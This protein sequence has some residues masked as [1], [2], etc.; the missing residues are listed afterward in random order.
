MTP[1]ALLVLAAALAAESAAAVPQYL[2][3]QG[4]LADSAGNPLSGA[5]SFRFKFFDAATGG[6]ELYFE[7]RAGADAVAVA[8]GVYHVHLGSFSPGGL[9]ASLFDGA[10]VYLEIDVSTGAT[11]VGA[12]TLAPRERILSAAYAIHAAVAERLGAGGVPSIHT[13]EGDLLV[14]RSLV[15]SSA[16]LTSQNAAGYSLALSS[17]LSMPAGSLEADRVSASRLGLGTASPAAR[18]QVIGGDV[19]VGDPT[20]HD[21]TADEDLLVKGNL[22][23]DGKIVHHSSLS[24][25]FDTLGVAA[26]TGADDLLKVGAGSLTV[27]ASGLVGLGTTSP[28][29]RLHVVGGDVFVGSPEA[30]DTTSSEDLLVKGNVIVDGRFIHHSTLSQTFDTLGV[31]TPTFPGEQFRVA[32]ATLTVTASG[33]VGIGTASPATLLHL[34][35][36]ALTVDGRIGIGTSAPAAGLHLSSGALLVDGNPAAIAIGVSTLVATGGQV[37]V[38][39]SAPGRRLHVASPAGGAVLVEADD[40]SSGANLPQLELRGLSDSDDRLHLG[41]HTGADF[42]YLQALRQ[43]AGARPLLLNKDGGSVGVG[44]LNPA[45]AA[46]L[47][48]SG[49]DL[50]VGSPDVHD[51]TADEDLLVKGNLVVDGKIVHHSSTSLTFDALGV[52][53]RTAAGDLLRVGAGSLT[54]RQDGAVGVGAASPDARLHVDAGAAA[55][56]VHFQGAN[57]SG[58]D[59]RF[60]LER[61]YASHNADNGAVLVLKDAGDSALIQFVSDTAEQNADALELHAQAGRTLSMPFR[62]GVDFYLPGT[63]HTETQLGV[64]LPEQAVTNLG[65][66]VS[67]GFKGVLGIDAVTLAATGPVPYANAAALYVK[68]PVAGAN[69]T[70]ANRYGLWVADGASRFDGSVAI[71]AVQPGAA[72]DVGGDAQFGSTAKS[73]FTAAGALALAAGQDLTLAGGGTVTGLPAPTDPADAVPKSYIDGQA[74]GWTS[75][76]GVVASDPANNVVVGSTLTVQGAA[77]SVGAATLAVLGGSVGVGTAAP[78]AKLHVD[79]GDILLEGGAARALRW[80][81]GQ[82]SLQN[83][84]G[85]GLRLWADSSLG[86]AL[87]QSSSAH[88]WLV[89]TQLAAGAA[90]DAVVFDNEPGAVASS[91]YA[92]VVR[93]GGAARFGVLGGGR[94]HVASHLGVGAADPLYRLHVSSG[95]GE[96]GDLVVVS[97]GATTVFRVTGE[98]QVSAARFVGDGSALTNVG[99]TDPTKLPTSGGAMTGPLTLSG[100]SLTVTGSG[101]S[102]GASTLVVRNGRLGLGTFDPTNRFEVVGPEEDLVLIRS[103]GAAANILMNT[104][105]GLTATLGTMNTDGFHLDAPRP[106]H[107]IR[108]YTQSTPSRGLTIK[109]G[110]NVGLG[111]ETPGASRLFVQGSD[112]EEFH[113]HVASQDAVTSLLVV[114]KLGRVGIGTAAPASRLHLSGGGLT[115]ESDGNTQLKDGG[116]DYI[117][118]QCGGVQCLD[119]GAGVSFAWDAYARLTDSDFNN[120]LAFSKTLSAVNYLTVG[121]AAAGGEPTLSASGADADVS[122]GLLPKGSGGVGIGTATPGEKLEVNGKTRL[123]AAGADPINVYVVVTGAAEA[124]ETAAGADSVCLAAFRRADS[125]AVSCA[126]A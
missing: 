59:A 121:N 78:G 85:G 73:T 17:G 88:D 10:N 49:G 66:N 22:V 24:L 91:R 45:S 14:G 42:G 120:Y 98:G 86:S 75:A 32:A 29:G 52:A 35:T 13:A 4:K 5:Y 115:F 48:V 23:V 31:A 46:A 51:V 7:E 99:G 65:S 36:G 80:G 43:G 81:A 15:A 100:S 124:C 47:H 67:A 9:P 96:A 113:V 34:G 89:R 12:E 94:A 110:G 54:V 71:G 58:L 117:R 37:G 123:T 79:G 2:N 16:T 33:R 103:P 21:T 109:A 97:T 87:L 39:T 19:L 1:G 11:L 104:S 41:F 108:L 56:V 93:E 6:A 18:L 60:V 122:I 44:T 8:N 114:D 77:F 90:A 53:T 118:L 68:A 61:A 55:E 27:R 76:G 84:A 25:T 40:T 102:V 64:G 126:D 107:D 83:H 111:T 26:N 119:L 38:G 70:I 62:R 50:Y 125:V 69:V 95:A 101:F 105:V 82:P 116:G 72:L 57:A 63:G 92:F 112:I 20:P 106:N 30:H 28:I 3:Y 74:A